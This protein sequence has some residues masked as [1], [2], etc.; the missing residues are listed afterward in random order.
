MDKNLIIAGVAGIAAVIAWKFKPAISW[1]CA[2]A[3]AYFLYK[4][5]RG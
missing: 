3:A 5:L 1:I 2:A 4:K